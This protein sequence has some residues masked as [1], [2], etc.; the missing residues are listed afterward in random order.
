[1]GS[2]ITS[3]LSRLS[4]L[5]LS[6]LAVMFLIGI[7]KGAVAYARRSSVIKHHVPGTNAIS[8][9][10]A[11]A[12][13]AAIVVIGIQVR[14]SRSS[15]ETDHPPWVAPFSRN[16]AS[17]L[18]RTLRLAD[19]VSVKNLIRA[20]VTVVLVV[21][22]LY[23]PYR[24]GA[25]I[26]G[27]LDHNS[28]VNAWGGP[29]YVGA[30]LAHSLDSIIGFYVVSGLLSRILLGSFNASDTSARRRPTGPVGGG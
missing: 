16:A 11:L 1:M 6:L 17:R 21:V 26:I 12:I 20:V 3:P 7:A 30:L 22:A 27:G 13:A 8:V 10:I 24:I 15:K 14:R 25:E 18:G 28:T 29:T 19:G 23:A 5:S 9:H 2:S 4:P